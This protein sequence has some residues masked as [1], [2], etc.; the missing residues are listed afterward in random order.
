MQLKLPT[1]IILITY[2]ITHLIINIKSIKRIR[3]ITSFKGIT[4][5]KMP[6]LNAAIITNKTRKIKNTLFIINLIIN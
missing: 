6:N 2:N 5:L 4:V 1:V 3:I